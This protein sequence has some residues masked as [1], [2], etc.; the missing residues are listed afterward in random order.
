MVGRR[1][2]RVLTAGLVLAVAL[3]WSFRSDGRASPTVSPTPTAPQ[4]VFR[5]RV[6]M[7]A[8]ALATAGIALGV[9]GY[10]LTRTTP[11]PPDPSQLCDY[12]FDGRCVS[13]QSG[14][15]LYTSNP[16]RRIALTASYG[17]QIWGP[18]ATGESLLIG[19]DV[20][21]GAQV[22]WMVMLYG[23]AR[24]RPESQRPGSGRPARIDLSSGVTL[25]E[26]KMRNGAWGN[27]VQ[28]LTGEISGP[29]RGAAILRAYTRTPAG[30]DA[31]TIA[32]ASGNV[33]GTVATSNT[34]YTVARLP[35][36]FAQRPSDTPGA[37]ASSPMWSPNRPL[38]VPGDWYVP[39]HAFVAESYRIAPSDR[40]VSA[41]PPPSS[42][43][44]A[45]WRSTNYVSGSF[46][47]IN[48]YA[49]ARD[50][51]HQF[52]AGIVLGLCGAT[53]IAAIQ[54][55]AAPAGRTLRIRARK[56]PRRVRTQ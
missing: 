48:D 46:A 6:W 10:H 16:A 14:I 25:S 49:M 38:P 33:D 40:V 47:T 39:V 18:K 17:P 34:K 26:L 20:P 4:K 1:V 9:V 54:A 45:R 42:V 23:V 51:R 12:Q 53:L 43:G 41:D 19:A 27:S 36:V 32:R 29:S 5:R 11:P 28:V 15:Y 2:I 55:C 56:R 21:A 7:S 30:Y 31:S 8:L 22:R 35:Y 44:T 37:V 13:I 3:V 24:L 50:T 52:W